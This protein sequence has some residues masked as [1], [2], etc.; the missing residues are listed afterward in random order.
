MNIEIVTSFCMY[1]LCEH[2]Q[3]N[4]FYIHGEKGKISTSSTRNIKRDIERRLLNIYFIERQ[5]I[6]VIGISHLPL[7]LD[8]IKRKE[9]ISFSI[10]II[11][12]DEELV[13]KV[14]SL[15]PYLKEEIKFVISSPEAC[16]TFFSLLSWDSF[17]GYKIIYNQVVVNL[18]PQF[19]KYIEKE[20]YHYVSSSISDLLTRMEFQ[21]IWIFNS[22]YNVFLLEQ[23]YPISSLLGI[24]KEGHQGAILVSAGPSLLASLDFLKQAQHY[25]FIACVDAAYS[26]LLENKIHVDLVYTLDGQIFTRNHLLTIQKN[27][28]QNEPLLVADVVSNSSFLKMWTQL[29]YKKVC[30]A[31]TVSYE[32]N[33]RIT[34]TGISFLEDFLLPFL[35]GCSENI[36]D[37]IKISIGD[38]QSGGSVATSLFDLL[39]QMDFKHIYLCGQDLAF[40]NYELHY[41]G[42]YYSKKWLSS[43][44]TRFETCEDIN[45]H[46]IQK[47]KLK[48]VPSIIENKYVITDFVLCIYADWFKNSAFLM[49]NAQIQNITFDGASLAP[50]TQLKT[51]ILSKNFSKEM[52]LDLLFLREKLNNLTAVQLILSKKKKIIEDFLS[53]K[54]LADVKRNYSFLVHISKKYD[55]LLKRLDLTNPS[56]TLQKE[57]LEAQK[58]KEQEYFWFLLK[59]VLSSG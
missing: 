12:Y 24:A 10:C 40:T 13:E 14:F 46:G 41:F 27:K 29:G 3:H 47:K 36:V 52:S 48:R 39:R 17:V 49:N 26:I 15:F 16:Y 7:L 9:K 25:L 45:F 44:V 28:T 22:L 32:K 35:T 59:K 51:S 57:H 54:S 38:I 42:N 18:K 37:K 23:Y 31:N 4:I 1:E 55:F 6:F 8:L 56:N 58:N 53:C 30:L 19:Y 33:I 50:I 20:I 11:E 5:I 2:E 34:T 21:K 43:R